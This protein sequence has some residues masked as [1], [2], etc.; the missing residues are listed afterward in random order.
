MYEKKKKNITLK[1]TL[2]EKAVIHAQ[3]EIEIEKKKDVRFQ[4]HIFVLKYSCC[5]RPGGR[6]NS[7]ATHDA[8]WKW[9]TI[10]KLNTTIICV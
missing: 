6:R 9:S 2:A 1:G 4:F 7:P 3:T 5:L 8:P 10:S